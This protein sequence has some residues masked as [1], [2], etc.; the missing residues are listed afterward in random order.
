MVAS[1]RAS[2]VGPEQ[3]LPAS[4]HGEFEE[5]FEGTWFIRGGLKM[6]MR[7]PMKIGRSMTV[8]RGDDGL[9][10]FNSMR[11]TDTGLRD[12][13]SLGDVKHIVRLGGFHGRDDGFYRDRFG[14]MIHAVEGQLPG[15]GVPV[16]GDAKEKFRPALEG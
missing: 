1:S 7:I 8:V 16:L 9:I 5:V 11:L 15:H 6:P 2:G 10:L 12:L 14:A 4:P 3:H 13:Q